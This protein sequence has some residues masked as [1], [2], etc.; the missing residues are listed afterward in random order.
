LPDAAGGDADLDVHAAIAELGGAGLAD[1]LQRLHA[2]AT[3]RNRSL[4]YRL[5]L[6][7]R[8]RVDASSR[9]I[10]ELLAAPQTQTGLGPG[11]HDE[12]CYEFVD[13]D[14]APHVPQLP[15][16]PRV[17]AAPPSAAPPAAAALA[18]QPH[19]AE[20]DSLLRQARGA[21]AE[22]ELLLTARVRDSLA[23]LASGDAPAI[24][25]ASVAGAL[26]A[27]LS[28][29]IGQ[30]QALHV[31]VSGEGAGGGKRGE[32]QGAREEAREGV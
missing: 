15:R 1:R 30:M 16:S 5:P 24:E 10:E 31:R 28:D 22:L 26:R 27:K 2:L 23:V 12:D 8:D 19:V 13:P 6:A 3:A 21:A 14:A 9:R 18:W 20:L 25:E 4:L 32:E 7:A 17:S 11:L 29:C